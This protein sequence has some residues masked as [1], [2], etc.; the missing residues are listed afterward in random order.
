[1]FRLAFHQMHS[2]ARQSRNFNGGNGLRLLPARP[3]RLV[4]DRTGIR[5]ALLRRTLRICRHVCHGQR[6]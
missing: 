5:N 3:T 6:P 1:V 2:L 4:V